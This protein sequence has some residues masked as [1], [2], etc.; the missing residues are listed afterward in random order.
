MGWIQIVILVVQAII[1]FGPAI[2]KVGKEV[3]E[4]VESKRDKEIK[5]N[6]DAK[7][8]S[9][10]LASERILAGKAIAKLPPERMNE[11][12]ETVW[13]SKNPGKNP[14]PLTDPALRV[15]PKGKWAG[16]IPNRGNRDL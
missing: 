9:F 11:L 7:A 16:K 6:S 13:A 1:K 15:L 4:W 5:L 8:L 2:Y 12:R 3:Y 10:N 14:K